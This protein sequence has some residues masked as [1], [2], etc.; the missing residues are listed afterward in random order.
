MPPAVVMAQRLWAAEAA[1]WVAV[2]IDNAIPCA[3]QWGY[4]SPVCS[5]L[6]KGGEEEWAL[7]CEKAV[8]KFCG[9]YAMLDG[10]STSF[11]LQARPAPSPPPRPLTTFP[12]RPALGR[13]L[14]RCYWGQRSL[15][16]SSNA[17]TATDTAGGCS[18]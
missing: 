5:Q 9:S 16:K 13:P 6:P 12:A 18:G 8:A 4:P 3:W 14:G 10:G 17:S 11:A 15:R 1:S 7:L 2:T